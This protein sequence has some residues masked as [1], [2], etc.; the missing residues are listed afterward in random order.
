M[1]MNKEFSQAIKKM[2][3]DRFPERD[4]KK[5]KKFVSKVDIE[6]VET[7]RVDAVFHDTNGDNQ[8]QISFEGNKLETF[9]L[10]SRFRDCGVCHHVAA[11]AELIL[12]EPEEELAKKVCAVETRPEP[13]EGGY[14]RDPEMIMKVIKVLD[15]E[16]YPKLRSFLGSPG[17]NLLD[18]LKKVASGI[19]SISSKEQYGGYKLNDLDKEASRWISLYPLVDDIDEKAFLKVILRIVNNYVRLEERRYF[20]GYC[21]IFNSMFALEKILPSL[22]KG[23]RTHFIA[24]LIRSKLEDYDVLHI[25]TKNKD[26]FSSQEMTELTQLYMENG[27]DFKLSKLVLASRNEDLILEN[28]SEF[29]P[30]ELDE[31]TEILVSLGKEETAEDL[32]SQAVDYYLKKADLRRLPQGIVPFLAKHAPEQMLFW[33]K[34][35][36]QCTGNSHIV[37]SIASGMN[38]NEAEGFK[39]WSKEYLRENGTTDTV[40]EIACMDKDLKLLKTIPVDSIVFAQNRTREAA[41]LFLQEDPVYV[42]DLLFAYALECCQQYPERKTYAKVAKVLRDILDLAERK[43]IEGP[44]LDTVQKLK[45]HYSRRPSFQEQLK[46]ERL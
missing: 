16:L 18:N 14:S 45:T 35:A 17:D 33:G 15:P 4:L 8:T 29:T 20:P 9:C 36:I 3:E 26:L 41:T 27:R 40:F 6:K 5:G 34:R 19:S 22:D 31:A 2:L 37:L 38:P 1:I 23:N 44:I 28:V 25:I 10:C 24:E 11:L 13:L 7:D 46:K 43:G 42:A 39:K 32:I 21:S 30:A 12:S